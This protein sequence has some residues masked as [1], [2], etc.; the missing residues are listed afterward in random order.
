VL[1]VPG[2][3]LLI[4]FFRL[5]LGISSGPYLPFIHPTYHLE[6][7]TKRNQP[8]MNLSRRISKLSVEMMKSANNGLFPDFNLRKI[9]IIKVKSRT[10]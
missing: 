6:H 10:F 8:Q 2:G 1:G 9:R 3:R 7:F 5:N 4:R